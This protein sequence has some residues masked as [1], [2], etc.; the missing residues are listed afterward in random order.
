[1]FHTASIFAFPAIMVSTRRSAKSR[2]NASSGDNGAGYHSEL[3]EERSGPLTA[4]GL[5]LEWRLSKLPGMPLDILHEVRQSQFRHRRQCRGQYVRCL[6]IFS[7]VHPVDLLWMSW[8][9][10][11]FR[12]ALTSK[13]SRWIWIVTFDNIPEVTFNNHLRVLRT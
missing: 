1:M 3:E 9:S 5:R 7:L 2:Q 13:S 8:A 6:Q 4:R 11:V 10:N 12:N